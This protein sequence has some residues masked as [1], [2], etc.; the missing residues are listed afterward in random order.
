[1]SLFSHG[2]RRHGRDLLRLGPSGVNLVG[3]W[4]GGVSFRNYTTHRSLKGVFKL[5]LA[6]VTV[7]ALVGTGYSIH[8]LNQPRGHIINEETAIPILEELPKIAPS[9]EVRFP[10]DRSGLKLTLF[11][12]QTCPFCCKVRAFLDYYGISYDV[13]EVDPVL[14]QS[15]KWSPYKKVP[16]LVA[17]LPQGYQPLNDS[18][19]IISA[20]STYIKDRKD[21]RETVKCYPHITYVD[22]D[23]SKKSE[24]M[25]KYFLVLG[26]NKISRE[27]NEERQWRKWVDEVFVHVLSPNVYRTREEAFE[28]FNWF[29]EVGEWEKNFPSWERNLIIFVGASAMYLIGKKLQKKYSLKRDVRESFYDECN[30]WMK[31]IKAK[32]TKFMG[33]E[34][35]NLADLAVYGVLCSIEGCQ[36][37]KDI[38]KHTKIAEWYYPMKEAVNGHE[39]AQFV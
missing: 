28:A 36:A 3:V 17:D 29:S 10:E 12:Y 21:L 7:G 33:G 37:F 5:G 32:G 34:R 26:E 8:R 30:F 19:M 14:R 6:G 20:L 11:Q 22:E 9:R 24:I 39:G 35:P 18:S 1:M 16:I 4:G 15:I 25:N 31:S 2:L 38:V 13:V 27:I 23:G